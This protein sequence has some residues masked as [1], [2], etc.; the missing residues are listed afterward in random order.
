M[1]PTV[2]VAL[3]TH[4]FAHGVVGV[5]DGTPTEGRPIHLSLHTTEAGAA[6]ALV[7]AL[8]EE[9]DNPAK[10]GL[11]YSHGPSEEWAEDRLMDAA[12]DLGYALTV[13]EQSVELSE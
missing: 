5:E 6:S 4:R 9:W 2:F 13:H 12:A 1:I 8:R 7:A 10:G 11:A 3:L